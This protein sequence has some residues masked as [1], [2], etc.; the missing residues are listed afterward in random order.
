[1]ISESILEGELVRLRPMEPRD[2][3][4]FVGWLADPEVRRWLAALQEPPTL[5]DELD[6]YESTR[7][8]PDN[9][10]WSME[11]IEGQLIGTIE[12]RLNPTSRR[13]ELGIAVQDKAQ[14]SKGFG[15]DAIKLALEYG[16]DDLEL[17]RIELTVDS[18][19][20]RGRRCYE[21]CGFVEEGLLRQHRFVEGK[22]GDT[23]VMSVL[24]SEWEARR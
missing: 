22:F 20:A 1:L 11:T 17:N 12:L 18:E 8:N 6:W 15:T 9:V 21:K 19:N 23:V 24:R 14:W 4:K 3:P 2:L 16:F 10:L 5:E 7:A 13:A